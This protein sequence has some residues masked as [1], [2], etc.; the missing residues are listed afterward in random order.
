MYSRPPV[1]RYVAILVTLILW[2]VADVGKHPANYQN[3]QAWARLGCE[4]RRFWCGYPGDTV[5]NRNLSAL[6]TYC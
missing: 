1:Y 3:S 5:M 2:I 6:S 4:Y